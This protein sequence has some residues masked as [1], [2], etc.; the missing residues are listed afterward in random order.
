MNQKRQLLWPVL[1]SVA[2]VFVLFASVGLPVVAQ[3]DAT[4]TPGAP[5]DDPPNRNDPA[6]FYADPPQSEGDAEWTISDR[7]FES[8]YP[9]GFVFTIEA[10]SSAG[11]IENATVVWSH[12]PRNTQRRAA[13]LDEDEGVFVGIYEGIATDSIPP[14]VAV[15]YQWRF[16]D[17]EGNT[18]TSQW[19][20]GE[21]YYTL[22]DDWRRYE[23]DDIIVF[24]ENGLPE[25]T[26]PMTL[27][28]MAAQRET[29]RLAW[30]ALLSNK[31]RAILFSNRESWSEWRRGTGNPN[32]IG[33]TSSEWG[34]IAQVVS[35]GGVVDLTY[36]TVLHEVGHLY[37]NEFAAPAFPAGSWWTEGNATFFELN[38][39]YDLEQRVRNL[40]VS[41]NL[42][43]LLAGTGPNPA[44]RGPD[45]I[46][47]LGY[48]IGYTFFKWLVLNYGLDV[49]LQ[50]LEAMDGNVPRNV[51][52][53][54]V[55]GLSVEE[56]ESR[57]RVWLGASPTAP[58]LIPTQPMMFPPTPTPFGQ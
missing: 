45:G 30:G 9:N 2:L 55:T 52:L 3:G 32:V 25:E 42:P 18:Y 35:R 19:F 7:T 11:G 6:V 36:G 8:F 57:W 33:Q 5:T 53:E 27:D 16:T 23:S 22:N 14:W 47:R 58:T 44:G 50:L 10:S 40:A 24:V 26:G 17:V 48:D 21:E 31:P 56:L 13:E 29:Y 28:A 41:G 54:E 20:T 1:L 34:G 12:S 15:A 49:H 43:A 37:Q 38:Q 39:Q 51:A 4:P 46:G